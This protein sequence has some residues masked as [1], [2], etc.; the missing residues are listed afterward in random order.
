MAN[1]TRISSDKRIYNFLVSFFEDPDYGREH[2]TTNLG[3][4]SSNLF[5]RA[6]NY[7]ILIQN[8][9]AIS[10][11]LTLDVSGAA[12]T[13]ASRRSSSLTIAGNRSY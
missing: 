8:L 1:A 11:L 2:Q 4:K 6:N 10:G 9:C 7:L 3:V 5:G 12:I 13:A